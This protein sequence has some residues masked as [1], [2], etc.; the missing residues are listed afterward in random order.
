MERSPNQDAA[1]IPRQRFRP[2]P[3][4]RC[5][6]AYS[7]AHRGIA[8][9]REVF[10]IELTSAESTAGPPKS[11]TAWLKERRKSWARLIRR[12][13]EADPLL[14]R[15]GQR[16]RVVGF[17]TQ[18]P[19]IR[20]ILDHVGRRFEPL[21]LPGRAATLP[22]ILIGPVFRLRFAIEGPEVG[23]FDVRRVGVALVVRAGFVDHAGLGASILASKSRGKGFR[24]AKC[25]RSRPTGREGRSG[26]KRSGVLAR[27][28]RSG[29]R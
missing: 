15:C 28:S 11:E 6:I 16:M 22:G 7:N 17:I 1:P 4:E 24:G 21:V 14:C 2:R 12:V 25:P 3:R 20:K 5:G 23:R 29:P 8:A 9:R 27:E 13:Y 26:R 10:E 18:A 19:V